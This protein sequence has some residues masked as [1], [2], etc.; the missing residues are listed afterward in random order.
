MM[1]R[2]RVL[3]FAMCLIAS[4]G[5]TSV[6]S[7]VPLLNRLTGETTTLP[8]MAA[9]STGGWPVEGDQIGDGGPIFSAPTVIE[10]PP[11]LP[12]AEVAPPPRV[13]P[14]QPMAKPMPFTPEDK[15]SPKP[16]DP[17]PKGDE[18]GTKPEKP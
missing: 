7:S 18:Q 1:T 13:V 9:D 2:P 12:P 4:P 3:L 5:C 16:P 11:P 8:P 10:T 6:M 15:E 14:E 17:T